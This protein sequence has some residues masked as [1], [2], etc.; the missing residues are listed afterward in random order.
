MSVTVA[1]DTRAPVGSTTVP[2]RDPVDTWVTPVAEKTAVPSKTSDTN[3][4][5]ELTCMYL[6][7]QT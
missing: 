2:L 5:K 7:L 6:L 4:K 3:L 1:S